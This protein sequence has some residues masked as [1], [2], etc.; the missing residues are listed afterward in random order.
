M[1]WGKAT[2]VHS[3]KVAICNHYLTSTEGERGE[4]KSWLKTQHSKNEDHGI[5]FHHFMA[6]RWG[7]METVTPFIFLGSKITADSDCSHETKRHLFLWRKA[8]TNL[9]SILKSRG[10][11]LLTKVHIVKAMVFFSSQVRKLGLTIKEGWGLK[12]WCF[13]IVALEKTLLSPLDSKYI[14]PVNPKGNQP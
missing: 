6:N 13:Q 7:K 8:M 5:Q 11:T 10:I 14:K 1:H 12:N 4:W 2:W 3:E 9:D